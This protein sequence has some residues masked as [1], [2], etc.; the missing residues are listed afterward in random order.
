VITEVTYVIGP[1]WT[2]KVGLRKLIVETMSLPIKPREVAFKLYVEDAVVKGHSGF[3]IR[4]S[5]SNGH[6]TEES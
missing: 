5:E 6:R 3:T 4:I 1:E 2:D